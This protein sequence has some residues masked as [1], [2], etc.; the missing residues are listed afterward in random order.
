[1]LE[2]GD[3]PRYVALVSG[4]NVGETETSDMKTELLR[5]F[6]TGELGSLTVSS[7]IAREF[8]ERQIF[9][10]LAPPLPV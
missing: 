5:E 4:L 3:G 2:L 7:I 1:M 9:I 8:Q 10:Y 6:L